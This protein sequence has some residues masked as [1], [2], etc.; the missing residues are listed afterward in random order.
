MFPL[1]N[2]KRLTRN[3]NKFLINFGNT[4]R[5]RKSSVP[6]MQSLLNKEDRAFQCFES[7]CNVKYY[8]SD[9]CHPG[10][11]RGVRLSDK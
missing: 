1:N 9:L 4:E 2:S 11:Y 5:Y 6:Y 10:S 3:S 8:A 7:S